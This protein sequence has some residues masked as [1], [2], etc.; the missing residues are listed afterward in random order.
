M[1]KF[2]HIRYQVFCIF[3]VFLTFDAGASQPDSVQILK[4]LIAKEKEVN[5]QV[6]Y[7]LE[8]SSLVS[9]QNPK[10]GLNYGK[11]GLNVA[12]K[13]NDQDL[14]FRCLIAIG[15][16]YYFLS[17]YDSSL[18]YLNKTLNLKPGKDSLELLL[19][20]NNLKGASY[21]GL[22]QNDSAE[23]YLKK[24]IN[25][26]T[27]INDSLMQAALY[28]NLGSLYQFRGSL[29][30]ALE[31][32]HKALGYYEK[33]GEQENLAITLNN[34]GQI[35]LSMGDFQR[36][37]QYTSRALEINKRLNN[38]YNISQNYGNLGNIYYR[39]KDYGKAVE[40]H[41]KSLDMA[42]EHNFITD[43]A[44]AFNNLGLVFFDQEKYGEALDYFEQSLKIS[45][46]NN[47]I[48]G[49][50]SNNLNI[51]DVHL[52][53]GSPFSALEHYQKACDLAI[54][55]DDMPFLL[56]TYQ[57]LSET[58][59]K[60]NDYNQSLFFWKKYASLNDSLNEIANKKQVIE[61]QTRYE[62]DKK[63]MEN[64]RLRI[65]NEAKKRIIKIQ[66]ITV[67][68]FIAVVILLASLAYTVFI[69][70]RQ[71]S[72]INRQLSILNDRTTEQNKA[73]EETNA[74]KDKLFSIIAHDLK[75][76]FNGLLGYLK[77]FTEEFEYFSNTEKKE[78]LGA[79][80]QQSNNTYSMLENL[81]QWARAQRGQIQY[82][83]VNSEIR[84][85]IESELSIMT[86]RLQN[87][88]ITVENQIMHN[89]MVWADPDHFRICIR[90]ILNN[91]IK[92]TYQ[93]GKISISTE[94]ENGRLKIFITDNGIG[95]DDKTIKTLFLP[96]KKSKQGT[97]KELG[98]GLGLLLV[99]EFI[100]INKGEIQ[101]A[102]APGNGTTFTLIFPTQAS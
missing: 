58:H 102:S 42:R 16:N 101:V 24:A 89:L 33:A 31:Y 55:H 50:M 6:E 23:I 22:M 57:K 85:M 75:S 41:Q 97:N 15:A 94:S 95:M 87:K 56:K 74:T 13:L 39:L 18:H 78:I 65:E 51:G 19:K 5:K 4:D 49:I 29:Q 35:N 21:R 93:E 81:L 48:Y 38:L 80:Y 52:I 34:I 96:N 30:T 61:L 37:I 46:D 3:V 45:E 1:I 60:L 14:I 36:A 66:W 20:T 27:A 11:T 98:T 71:I 28:I 82:N 32:Y 64:E 86:E 44:R 53:T 77:L 68:A 2:F 59:E 12:E 70:K 25:Y 99:K 72:R 90:N 40:F 67:A 17:Q 92:Y 79:L 43:Q 8:L 100:A 7:Y 84:A 91:A 10:E 76:P 62:S 83:P 73:L 26:G 47:L 88:K 9:R 69:R 54:R 63:E